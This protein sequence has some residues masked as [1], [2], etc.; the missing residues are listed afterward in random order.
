MNKIVKEL[1]SDS[2]IK[3]GIQDFKEKLIDY[4]KKPHYDV[5][6]T[7]LIKHFKLAGEDIN[8]LQYCLDKLANKNILIKSSSFDHFEYDLSQE[9]GGIH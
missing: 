5:T 6:L 7:D 3:V 8:V 4:F 2:S 9:Y 1:K